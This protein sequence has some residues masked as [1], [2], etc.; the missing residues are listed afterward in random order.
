MVTV[1]AAAVTVATMVGCGLV[2]GPP[3]T[4]PASP[5]PSPDPQVA[6]V[7]PP[8]GV[9]LQPLSPPIEVP[10]PAVPTV[11]GPYVPP[12][13]TTASE[14]PSP[15]P[16]PSPV[17]SPPT[18]TT[19]PPPT[20]PASLIALLPAA[21][22]LPSLTWRGDD[23]EQRA[24]WSEFAP[25]LRVDP[26]LAIAHVAAARQSDPACGDPDAVDGAA[27]DAAAM[28]FTADPAPGGPF[29]LVVLRYPSALA[30]TD[31]LEALQALGAACEGVRTDA[32][33]LGAGDDGAV[34]LRSAAAVLVVEAAALDALL[35]A[36][37][38]RGAPAQAVATL[39]A[40]TR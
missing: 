9:V 14:H 22:E 39:L 31:A 20:L 32:G 6:V 11:Q 21:A 15:T 5:P 10:E 38:H 17:S 4:P 34:V 2:S 40:S 24:E 12:S 35:V 3:E 28:T 7:A 36:V 19:S 13:V 18:P 33:V 27:I 25:P 16:A 23:G 37:L 30:A 26:A 8:P 1:A 29:E